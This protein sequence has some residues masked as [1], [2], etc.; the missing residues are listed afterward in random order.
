[1]SRI[2]DD[3]IT[4]ELNG[5][6]Y[7]ARFDLLA[8]AECQY[9]LKSRGHKEITVPKL[10]QAIQEEDYF[11]ICNLLAFAIKSCNPGK[12]LVDIYLDMKFAD[13]GNVQMAL[14][15]LIQASMPKNDES[16]KEE[17]LP[18]SRRKLKSEQDW[19]LEYYQYIWTSILN[20]SEESFWKLTPRKLFIQIDKHIEYNTPKDKTEE[21][22]REYV[23]H[24][25]WM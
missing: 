10:F 12:K 4:I 22:K 7:Q 1:M 24:T 14:M 21:K 15:E 25:E 8:I 5:Q 19:D 13:R 17:D 9:Y 23:N 16:K 6:K 18:P 20:R 3:K 2:L 11:V